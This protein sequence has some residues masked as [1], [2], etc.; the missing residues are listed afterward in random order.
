MQAYSKAA[1]K[2]G[3]EVALVPTMGALHQGHLSLVDVARKKVGP[4]G[5]VIVSIYVNPTQFG[6]G[7]D[8][9][10]YPRTF[11]SDRDKCAESGVDVIFC[12]TDS[13]MYPQGEAGPYSVYV[14]EER[15]S[16]TMEGASRPVHFRGVT[17][18]V[19]KLFNACLP[20]YAVFGAKDFQQSA[21]IRKMV[22]D[23]N[24]PIEIIVAP[25]FREIDGLAMSSRNV[26]L[27]PDERSQAV[28]L[29]LVLQAVRGRVIEAGTPVDVSV[30][31]DLAMSLLGEFPLVSLD[32]LEFFNLD[33]LEPVDPVSV[34]G[35]CAIAARLGSVRLIDNIRISRDW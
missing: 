34:G 28:A 21:I 13:E 12:P 17:T 14:I 22:R 35:H 16:K 18:I 4:T 8:F 29:S 20:D 26:K 32:Y 19:C 2:K 6:Q 27:S 11:D 10:S 3:R 7:E 31:R 30:L 9:D 1:V 25:T 23:L 33:S 24:F 5:M 15:L